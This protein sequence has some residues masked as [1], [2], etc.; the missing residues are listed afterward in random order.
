VLKDDLLDEPALPDAR[1]SDE[2]DDPRVPPL[3]RDERLVEERALGIRPTNGARP[4]R[5]SP[6]VRWSAVMAPMSYYK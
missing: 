2:R 6:Q 1:R 5:M 4:S 3:R